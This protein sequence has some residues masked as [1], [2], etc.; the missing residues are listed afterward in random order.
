VF[1]SIVADAGGQIVNCDLLIAGCVYFAL[2]G[3]YPSASVDG[4]AG[5]D[6][7]ESSDKV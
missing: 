3:H 1:D 5:I 7:S 6:W 2:D 4:F